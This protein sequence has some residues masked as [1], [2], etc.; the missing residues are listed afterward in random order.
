MQLDIIIDIIY[1]YEI[2]FIYE[3]VRTVICKATSFIEHCFSLV[4]L[5]LEHNIDRIK[6]YYISIII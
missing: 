4:Q 1:R 6:L 5:S 3:H 2:L